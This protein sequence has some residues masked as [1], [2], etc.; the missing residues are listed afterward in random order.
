M[1]E[2]KANVEDSTTEVELLQERSNEVAKKV[3]AWTTKPRTR[4][5]AEGS[6]TQRPS[7]SQEQSFRD[8]VDEFSEEIEVAGYEAE[9]LIIQQS[10]RVVWE[11][12]DAV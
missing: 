9:S 11:T 4:N 6:V 2:T 3:T 5:Q 10:S 1:T 12:V 8:G 7:P